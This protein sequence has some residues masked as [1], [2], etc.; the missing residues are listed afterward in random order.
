[1]AQISLLSGV[2]SQENADFRTSYPVN[3]IPVP[4]DTG[5]SKGYLRFA[6][7]LTQ[8]GTGPGIDRGG[9]VMDDTLFR[10]MGDKLV[11]VSSTG[12]VTEVGTISSDG[13]MASMDYSFD[14]LCVVSDGKAYLCTSGAV[15]QITDPDIGAPVDVVW[16]DG[17]FLFTDGEFLYVSDLA[18]P[19]A[20]D[21]LKYSS[22]EIDP[23]RVVGVLKYRNEVYA[24][25]RY[26]IEVFDNI[27][28]TGFPFTRLSGGLITKGCVGTRAKCLYG[29]TFAWVGSGRNEPCSVYIAA[30][31]AAQKIAT[32]E[33]EER[34]LAYTEAELAQVLVEAKADKLHQHLLIHL[35][36]E[37]LVYDAAASIAVGE[38]VWFFL[39]TGVTGINA[40]RARNF[41]F[42]Y[43]RWIVGDTEDGRIGYVDEDLCTQYEVIPGWQF[44]T[45]LLYNG[46][47][48][49]EVHCL[50]LVGTTGRA[51]LGDEPT[52]F[53][54][55]TLDG[56]TWSNE[57]QVT[58]GVRGDR[59]A[60]VQF[61]RR[62]KMR[63]FRGE[64]FRG[65]NATPISWVRLEA[66]LEGLN[67]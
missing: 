22:S 45:M 6:P 27:G 34:L 4:K 17:Y 19:F 26:T 2:T 55:Y 35:P 24:L 61:R 43:N 50:E 30:G 9:I 11:T 42:A 37:T 57:R 40:Y 1:V 41:T 23:D 12:T 5:I 46:G 47:K 36:N 39:S 60:R 32:R 44:D 14:Y 49:A 66:E 28:G 31:G 15:T 7:G 16:V 58:M 38:P 20:I 3:L 48:G 13:L 18:D 59:Q 29:E 63:N 51:A 56:M 54:S 21:P 8:L 52:V 25:N 33:V 64:R 10:V 62:G 65:A 53:H 67:A